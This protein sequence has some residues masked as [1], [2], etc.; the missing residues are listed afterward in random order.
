MMVEGFLLRREMEQSDVDQLMHLQ[1]LTVK[2]LR[3][4]S[5]MFAKHPEPVDPL[6]IWPIPEIDKSI[7]R[8]REIQQRQLEERAEKVLQKYKK[9]GSRNE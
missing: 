5:Q 4:I 3:D 1:R 6:D 8:A 7:Q 9:M 2:S